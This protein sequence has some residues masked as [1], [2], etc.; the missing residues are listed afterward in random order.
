M[1]L[2]RVKFLLNKRILNIVNNI[3]MNDRKIS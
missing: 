2:I 1:K 3:E